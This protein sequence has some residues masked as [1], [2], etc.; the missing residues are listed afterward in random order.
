MG[1]KLPSSKVRFGVAPAVIS[2]YYNEKQVRTYE[3]I[4]AD[5]L[6]TTDTKS[7][8][9]VAYPWRIEGHTSMGTQYMLELEWMYSKIASGTADQ[10]DKD[11]YDELLSKVQEQA[12]VR[13]ISAFVE[14]DG[15]RVFIGND[16]DELY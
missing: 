10:I 14:I 16:Y 11:R 12:Y 6:Y 1:S 15:E 4:N 7:P 2:E 13:P 3:Y 9:R 5:E 8:Y